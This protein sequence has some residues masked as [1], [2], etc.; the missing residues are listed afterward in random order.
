MPVRS[1]TSKP[2]SKQPERSSDPLRHLTFTKSSEK[3]LTYASIEGHMELPCRSPKYYLSPL[4]I[5][6]RR[7]STVADFRYILK[8]LNENQS[9]IEAKFADD[10]DD[11]PLLR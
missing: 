3:E 11:D 1:P 10:I 9:R 7:E 4:R 2:A 5:L 8:V 6:L